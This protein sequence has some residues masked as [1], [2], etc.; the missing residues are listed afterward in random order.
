MKNTKHRG[1]R[2]GWGLIRIHDSTRARLEDLIREA[3]ENTPKDAGVKRLNLAQLLDSAVKLLDLK[4]RRQLALIH[5]DDLKTKID[6]AVMVGV[7]TAYQMD[8]RE[9]QVTKDSD[10]Q[11]SEIKVDDAVMD[12]VAYIRATMQARQHLQ[13]PDEEQQ[14]Q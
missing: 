13:Q 14:L 3:D 8:G 12:P 5:P 9:V 1:N 6:E 4:V 10:G 11:V 7:L 2:D